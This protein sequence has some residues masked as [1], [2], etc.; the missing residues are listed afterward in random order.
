MQQ[1]NHPYPH[2]HDGVE[3]TRVRFV[4]SRVIEHKRSKNI[5]ILFG[6]MK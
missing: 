5:Q 1:H 3:N 2:V 4:A 6:Y